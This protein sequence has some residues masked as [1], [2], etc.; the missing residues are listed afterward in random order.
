[1]A[2]RAFCVAELKAFQARHD[3]IAIRA[4]R[5]W[6]DFVLARLDR[7]RPGADSTAY[8]RRVITFR[9]G[10]FP[11]QLLG[12]IAMKKASLLFVAGLAIAISSIAPANA[13]P[14]H[15]TGNAPRVGC[16]VA[17]GWN[18]SSCKNVGN[19]KSYS[20]CKEAGR[21]LEGWWYCS[22]VGFKN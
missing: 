18:F 6:P 22:S 2:K 4:K 8:R 17:G 13:A 3:L 15:A 5:T 9:D 7:G 19:W 20:E 10:H 12:D 14:V 1:M 21:D 16:S 11:S